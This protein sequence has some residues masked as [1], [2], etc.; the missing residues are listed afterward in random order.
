[1]F[2]QVVPPVPLPL[3]ALDERVRRFL[4]LGYRRI[5]LE[6]KPGADVSGSLA[7]PTSPGLGFDV[8]VDFL[9]SR[10]LVERLRG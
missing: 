10:T 5:K 4:G 7:V 1:M 2:A 3:D 6:I 8:D 9:E